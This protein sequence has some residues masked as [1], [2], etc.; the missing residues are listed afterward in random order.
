MTRDESAYIWAN[1]SKMCISICSVNIELEPKTILKSITE[2]RPSVIQASMGW[3]PIGLLFVNAQPDA[4]I[5][6][7]LDIDPDHRLTKIN[8][9]LSYKFYLSIYL[10]GKSR[11]L[12]VC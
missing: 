10:F 6:P 1:Q 12:R 8:T 7:Q 11:T 4:L 5:N 3:L 2:T 9:Q